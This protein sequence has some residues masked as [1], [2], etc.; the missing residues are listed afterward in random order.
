MTPERVLSLLMERFPRE[1]ASIEPTGLHPHA[2]VRAEAWPAIARFL[3]D[4]PR[5]G[6]D[7]LRCIVGVDELEEKT[8]VAIYELHATQPPEQSA[9]VEADNRTANARE[10]SSAGTGQWRLGGEIAIKVRV[11][12]DH[13]SIPS[14]ADVWPAA[15]WHEREAFDLFGIVFERHPDLRRILCCDDWVGH[16]LRKDYEFP[17]EYHGIPAVTEFGQS[18]PQH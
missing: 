17:L 9:A 12:R 3:R 18:R 1:V 14:V 7:W 15:N 11:E 8:M 6:F 10:P 4:D 2:V 5:L 16:P 13:P